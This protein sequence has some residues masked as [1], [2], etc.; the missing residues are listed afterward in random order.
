M[1]RGALGTRITKRT[2]KVVQKRGAL[3]F[4]H[5]YQLCL[6]SLLMA[7][8]SV[9]M[10]EERIEL[11]LAEG[12]R[13]FPA[14]IN[15]Q[16]ENGYRDTPDLRLLDAAYSPD[17]TTD[18][19]LHFDSGTIRDSAGRYRVVAGQE[20][21]TERLA[22]LGSGAGLFRR[23]GGGTTLTATTD[24]LF[25]PGNRWDDF[26]IEFWL[27]PLNLAHG[28]TIMHWNGARVISSEPTAEVVPQELRV[29]LADGR[30]QWDFTNLFAPISGTAFQLQLRGRRG[31]TPGVWQHHI[32]RFDSR[33]GLLEYLM[34]GVPEDIAWAT[35]DQREG[36]SVYPVMLGGDS[37]HELTVG[38][39]LDGLID[40]LRLTR[41][42]T[43][44]PLLRQIVQTSGRAESE[45]I[46]LGDSGG[47][48]SIIDARYLAPDN[49]A[50]DFYYHTATRSGLLAGDE[51]QWIEFRPGAALDLVEPAHFVRLR[52]DLHPDGRGVET[53]RLSSL[54][55]RY[56]PFRPPA[57][58][59]RL[60]AIPG[61]GHLR[62]SWQPAP[63]T[64][65][66][67]G[68]RVHIGRGP[69][70]YLDPE[71]RSPLDAG[72]ATTI[73]L[74]GLENGR[75]YYIAIEAYDLRMPESNG[76]YSSELV[77]RPRNN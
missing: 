37:N 1:K 43:A 34:N 48:L 24:A 57:A 19:L 21:T 54:T 51:P 58:P 20:H 72:A 71:G 50:I 59:L 5:L 9:S 38:G 26:S 3:I 11:G 69:Q 17:S 30:L 4:R 77:A 10:A 75:A 28:S 40:E 33:R 25:L 53:P 7:P 68:F 12:W 67:Q 44:E 31:L 18:L 62:L 29:W 60:E 23:T 47:Y 74:D 39:D 70:N 63:N 8:A 46:A 49:T 52:V 66:R 35:A 61:D 41:T 16:T 76:P 14:R 36:S 56:E 2:K 22:R 6:Y 27:Y 15:L 45:A 55:V 73:L 65:I 32:V 13:Q 64:G 42:S